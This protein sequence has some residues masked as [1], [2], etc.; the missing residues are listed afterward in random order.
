MIASPWEWHSN[1]ITA[2]M[3][4]GKYV[5][6]EYVVHFLWMNVGNWSIRPKL[7]ENI[8][9]FENVCYRR[10][11]WPSSIWSDKPCLVNYWHLEG[12]YQHR[13]T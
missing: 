4:A 2:A 6:T 12:G 5:A 13:F 7:Q 10:I 8:Y 3:K 1:M 11:L 9:S